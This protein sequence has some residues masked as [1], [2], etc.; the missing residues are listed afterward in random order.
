MQQRCQWS[1]A[2]TGVTNVLRLHDARNAYLWTKHDVVKRA[3]KEM[4]L[5]EVDKFFFDQRISLPVVTTGGE[6]V[7]IDTV[8]RSGIWP[9]DFVLRA[10]L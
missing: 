10:S 2:K 1:A 3:A 4:A 8:A 7:E 5:K 6:E 9:G